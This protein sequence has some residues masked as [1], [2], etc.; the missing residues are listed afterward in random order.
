MAQFTYYLTAKEVPC[1]EEFYEGTLVCDLT[2]Y[3]GYTATIE[4]NG[5]SYDDDEN[6]NNW[7]EIVFWKDDEELGSDVADIEGLTKEQL[8]EFCKR[9]LDNIIKE[10]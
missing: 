10:E 8:Q 3:N 9:E 7:Y 2:Y 1:S 5:E 4:V 6:T